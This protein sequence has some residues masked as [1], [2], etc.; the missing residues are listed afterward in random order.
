MRNKLIL[1]P[2]AY[3]GGNAFI[4]T[5]IDDTPYISAFH[6]AKC[7]MKPDTWLLSDKPLKKQIE[8][9]NRRVS[10]ED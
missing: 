3:C 9:W 7:E 5:G 2:C 4:T 8:A 6:T 1:L 10:D